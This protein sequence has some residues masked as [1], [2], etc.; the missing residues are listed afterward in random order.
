MASLEIQLFEK[1]VTF[2]HGI[3]GLNQELELNVA[4]GNNFMFEFSN[5]DKRST[6][7][8]RKISPSQQRRNDRRKLQYD[9][10]KLFKSIGTQDLENTARTKEEVKSETVEQEAR[11]I[12]LN[13]VDHTVDKFDK[14]VQVEVEKI[15]VGINTDGFNVEKLEDALNMDNNGNIS[16][17]EGEV[18][19]EMTVSHD[20][21]TW[22]DITHVIKE[23]LRMTILGGPWIANNGRLYKTIG[24][25]TSEFDYERWRMNTFN[26][27]ESGVRKVT[28]SR[29]YRK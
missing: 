3:I 22:E 24:F 8:I 20:L 26:W 2:V 28:T 5:M 21:K 9:Q 14:S 12:G 10:S 23:K 16:P 25:R 18:L 11:V 7:N 27:Q 1:C 13:T 15:E 17:A 6:S 29:L 4:I 19:V